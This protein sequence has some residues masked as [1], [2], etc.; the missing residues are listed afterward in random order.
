[1]AMSM[2][3]RDDLTKSCETAAEFLRKKL[4]N[5]RRSTKEEIYSGEREFICEVY[6][7]LVNKN[8]SYRNTLFVDYIPDRK[9]KEKKLPDLVFSDGSGNKSVVEMKVVVD[10]RKKGDLRLW[11]QDKKTVRHDYNKLKKNYKDF[12]SKFLVVAYL[13]DPKYEDETEF[14]IE[15]F[16]KAICTSFPNTKKIRVIVC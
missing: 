2:N 12:K 7:L 15:D 1:M 3:F 5:I 6:R 4:I 9:G 10:K 11:A 13:C 14:P 16:K 8:K